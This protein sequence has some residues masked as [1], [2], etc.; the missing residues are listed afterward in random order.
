MNDAGKLIKKGLLIVAALGL[1]AMGC[2]AGGTALNKQDDGVLAKI[3]KLDVVDS[4]DSTT[5][6]IDLDK[7]VTFTTVRLVDPPM[8]VV[9]LAG[10]EVGANDTTMKVDKGQ[11]SYITPSM[12]AVSKRVARV[13]I[14]LV[15][16][17][18]SSISQDGFKINIK[19]DKTQSAP[20]GIEANDAVTAPPSVAEASPVMAAVE[21]A[22][23][24]PVPA[25]VVVS[26]VHAEHNDAAVVEE[27]AEMATTVNGI[28]VKD[29]GSGLEISVEG[30]GRFA[31]PKVFMLGD[32]RLVLDL[33][34]LGAVKEKDTV[35]IGGDV[36]KRV[37]MARHMGPDGK[38]RVVVDLGAR[39]DYDVKAT[40]RNLVV[41]IVPAGKDIV[42]N[43]TPAPANAVAAPVVPAA[44]TPPVT[45][46]AIEPV[47]KK[48][49][50]TDM[51]DTKMTTGRKVTVSVPPVTAKPDD[52]ANIYISQKDGK[53]VLSSAPPEDSSAPAKVEKKD[54]YVVT[55]TKIY[56]GG[57]ISFDI[58]DAELSKVIKLLA[59][60]AGLNLIMDP[61]DVKGSVTLKLANVPWDQALD[62]LLKIYNLDKVLEGNVLRVAPKAKLD[63]EQKSDLKA[64]EEI[65]KLKEAAQDLYTKTFKI[66][67]AVATELEPQVKKTLSK[68]GEATAI[69][70]SNEIIVT[71]VRDKI[72]E[73]GDIIGILDKQ[74]NQ[75]MIE[76]RIVQVDIDYKQSLG[77]S[78]GLERH[79]S[80][81]GNFA[82]S[83]GPQND[84]RY[85]DGPAEDSSDD[86]YTMSVP[87]LLKGAGVPGLGAGFLL[88]NVLTD[89]AINIQISALES[90]G[91]GET[92][93]APKVLTL[94]NKAAEISSGK[95]I[96]VQSTSAAGT[97]PKPL[98]STLSLNVTPRVTGDNYIMMDVIATNNSPDTAPPP[99]GATA[100]INTQ[101]VNSSV[102][103][104]DGETIV[105]GG[106]YVKTKRNGNDGI[107]Y[108][109]NIPVLGWL[110]KQKTT[111]DVT[112]ELLI[113]ITP[114]IVKQQSLVQI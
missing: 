36:V 23:E 58:Q 81:G 5:V 76:A 15:S 68:R 48:P 47:A 1:L 88:G 80:D 44:V 89:S 7:D 25:Q 43:V 83:T 14:G 20:S 13:E 100:A 27:V 78:W 39:V 12:D 94:E 46:A 57:K 41:S 69:P 108:L 85:V 66:N 112:R 97:E 38:V 79:S 106:V 105:L 101:S 42:A 59:D 96:Y 114:K 99:P 60:V 55:E 8:M 17:A 87:E 10:V 111:D 56:T 98:K 77:I 45:V 49:A 37:R 52:G 24:A 32:D 3:Q 72:D 91:K 21:T 50:S 31:G 95:T 113:F 19:F 90:I 92:L 54:N 26:P 110:F 104:K 18:T 63:A 84:P 102:I 35:E 53:T 67:Y 86:F 64:I 6:V 109:S 70:R 74:V 62:I 73:V 30:D 2:S 65:K 34:G 11:V 28:S 16:P 51:V 22:N 107:P 61:N 93:A 75:I 71:D 40:G 82:I 29:N 103:V 33:P 4:A 9:D